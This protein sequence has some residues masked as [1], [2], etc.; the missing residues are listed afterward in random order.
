MAVMWSVAF[1][2]RPGGC[3]SCQA[4]RRAGRAPPR[5][6]VDCAL[7]FPGRHRGGRAPA[8]NRPSSAKA[9]TAKRSGFSKARGDGASVDCAICRVHC[10]AVPHRSTW[11][12]SAMNILLPFNSR[13]AKK[14]AMLCATLTLLAVAGASHA[15][16]EHIIGNFVVFNVV[17]VQTLWH[18]SPDEVR[19]A[20]WR[21]AYN[22]CK[23]NYPHTISVRYGYVS[24][25]KSNGNSTNSNYV[26]AVWYCRD[27]P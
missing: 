24:D 23:L 21:V 5:L 1:A 17:P 7:Y 16:N 22:A 6:Q 11:T 3:A 10:I 25:V 20:Q 19:K 8:C 2:R 9:M 14:G 12:E 13:P 18:P 15:S 4:F 27:T 26:N